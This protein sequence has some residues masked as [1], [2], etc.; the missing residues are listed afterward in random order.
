MD[1][2]RILRTVNMKFRLADSINVL[3]QVMGSDPVIYL[4]SFNEEFG[5]VSKCLTDAAIG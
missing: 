3:A 2:Q 1:A 5:N 4:S